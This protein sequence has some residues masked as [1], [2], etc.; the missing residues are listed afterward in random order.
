MEEVMGQ[1]LSLATL[2]VLGQ[3]QPSFG[4]GHNGHRIVAKLAETRLSS[5]A[6]AAIHDILEDSEDIADASTWPDEHKSPSDAPW[7][8]VNVPLAND[9]YSDEFCDAK[10][11]CVVQKIKD[12]RAVLQDPNSS[13][14]DKRRALRFVIH[15][16]G[17]IHQPLHVADNGDRGGNSVHVQFFGHGVNLHAIWDEYL[18]FHDPSKDQDAIGENSVDEGSWVVRLT[19]FTTKEKA[20]TW[21]GVTREEDWATESLRLA[22]KAYK[23]DPANPDSSDDVKKGARL[24]DDYENGGLPIVEQ[25]LAHAGVRLAQV[26]NDIFGND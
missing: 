20:K 3:G 7:H 10:K 26:L 22:K 6:R 9:S 8:Y 14:L 19:K 4:W 13:D 24:A 21:L 12:F 2:I 25:R 15:L 23:T 17:D 5:A 16:V 18:L 1:T 11:S